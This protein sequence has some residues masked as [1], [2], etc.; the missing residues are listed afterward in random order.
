MHFERTRHYHDAAC[1]YREALRGI[2]NE[3]G[4]TLH[5]LEKYRGS[6]GYA[7][8]TEAA[9]RRRNEAIKAL[10]DTYRE[11]FAHIIAGMRESATTRTME[12][13]T[14]E[15]LA[16]LQTLKMREKIS[17]A[18]LE[19]AGRTLRNSPVSL[20]VLQEIAQEMGKRTKSH[21]YNSLHFVTESTSGI[22]SC[23][24]ELEESARRICKLDKCDSR[25]D[26]TRRASVH[27]PEYS[28]DALYSF[29]V[30]HD[31]AS[32]REAMKYFGG[33]E[34]LDSFEA[35]VNE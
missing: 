17:P 8:E 11:K 7:E 28:H 3:Y 23:I 14:Q 21:E 12:P 31:V 20:S 35:A 5:K 2:W 15:Q 24:G 30:D 19:Q 1:S 13:P 22:L 6:P 33:V 10:Q 29:R 18:E 4:E 9:E 34:N 16:L 25:Q 32:V 26:M 27:S